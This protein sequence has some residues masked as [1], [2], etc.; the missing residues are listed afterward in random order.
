M[1]PAD[2]SDLIGRYQS[3]VALSH[4]GRE[5]GVKGDT[6]ANWFRH[7]GVQLRT[8]AESRFGRRLESRLAPAVVSEIVERY[9]AGESL[10]V[11]ATE[12][13]LSRGGI[14]EGGHKPFGLY[15]MLHRLGIQVRDQSAA[16]RVKWSHLTDPTRRRSQTHAARVNAAKSRRYKWLNA[17][18]SECLLAGGLL[19]LGE[20]AAQQAPVGLYNVDIALEEIRVAVEVESLA[21]MA[22]SNHARFKDRLEELCDLGWRVIYVHVNDG[23]VAVRPVAQKI[24]AL[25]EKARGGKPLRGQYGML[26]RDG[27]PCSVRRLNLDRFTRIPGY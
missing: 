6:V 14:T 5:L 16:E 21:S 9:K 27:E 22:P 4:L 20:Q 25:A 18:P 10:N 17:S 8:K 13:G 26:S 19:A 15:G 7:A 3:G 2:L 24:V 1:K 12:F 11:L 23:T